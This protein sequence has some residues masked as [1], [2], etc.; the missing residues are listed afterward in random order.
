MDATAPAE[1][2]FARDQATLAEECALSLLSLRVIAP[3]ASE[4]VMH[5]PRSEIGIADLTLKHVV[6]A[7]HDVGWNEPLPNEHATDCGAAKAVAQAVRRLIQGLFRTQTRSLPVER[8]ETVTAVP[9]RQAYVAPPRDCFRAYTATA[10]L[11]EP[12]PT[13]FSS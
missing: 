11:F 13:A 10:E 8:L 2:L 7:A 9:F 5:L 1:S 6:Q 4:H 12:S 3:D